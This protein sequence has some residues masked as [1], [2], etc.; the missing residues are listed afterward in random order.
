MKIYLIN[1]K[2]ILY[3]DPTQLWKSLGRRI[4]KKN[5]KKNENITPENSKFQ[6]N[7]KSFFVPSLFIY[8]F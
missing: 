2:F 7:Q 8:W 4:E 6:K 1:N 3:E 5:I